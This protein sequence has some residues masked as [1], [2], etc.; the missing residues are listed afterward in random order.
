MKE[1]LASE[2]LASVRRPEMEI[3]ASTRMVFPFA[4]ST[5]DGDSE[6]MRLRRLIFQEAKSFQYL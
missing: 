4:Y 3:T 5:I 1:A 2:F 6:K